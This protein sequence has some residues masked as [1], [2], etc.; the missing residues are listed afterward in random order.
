MKFP[1]W[2]LRWSNGEIMKW[3][4]LI[5][6]T[7]RPCENWSLIRTLMSGLW[8]SEGELWEGELCDG[9][10]LTRE[11]ALKTA[12]ELFLSKAAKP[13]KSHLMAVCWRVNAIMLEGWQLVTTIIVLHEP[14]EPIVLEISLYNASANSFGWSSRTVQTRSQQPNDEMMKFPWWN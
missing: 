1:W 10:R 12:A 4:N 9:T 5:Y 11:G 7:S 13:A 6:F 3:W 14:L 2:N 8:A